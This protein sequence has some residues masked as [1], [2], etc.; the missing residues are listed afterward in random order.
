MAREDLVREIA[1]ENISV[2]EA[3]CCIEIGPAKVDQTIDSG[4]NAGV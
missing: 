1:K 3:T 2:L 4:Y